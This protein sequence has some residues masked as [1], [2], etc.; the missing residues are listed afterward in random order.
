MALYVG[1]TEKSFGKLLQVQHN[2]TSGTVTSIT[3]SSFTATEVTDQITPSAS[4]SKIFVMICCSPSQYEDSGSLLKYK[5]AIYRQIDGGGYSRVYAGQDNTYDGYASFVS[6]E[7]SSSN[8]LVL[9][10]TDEP[11]TTN[12]VDYMLYLARAGTSNNVN[13]GASA[14]ERGVTLMEIGA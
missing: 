4:S 8:S 2:T 9:T 11:N 14:M 1:G 5:A 12:A 7:H 10:F 6:G 13:T 3:S